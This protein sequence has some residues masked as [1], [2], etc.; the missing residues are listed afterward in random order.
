M[1]VEKICRLNEALY[2]FIQF[3]SAWVR[4]LYLPFS[5]KTWRCFEYLNDCLSCSKL[6]EKKEHGAFD[7]MKTMNFAIVYTRPMAEFIHHV[8]EGILSVRLCKSRTCE[9]GILV[10]WQGFQ[11]DRSMILFTGGGVGL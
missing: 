3:L 11:L 5:G 7:P 10:T 1:A 2:S 6:Y 9:N 4:K 8:N